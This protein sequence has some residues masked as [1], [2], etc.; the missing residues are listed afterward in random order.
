M[1]IIGPR[2]TD[3]VAEASVALRLECTGEELVADDSRAPDVRRGGGRGGPRAARRSDSHLRDSMPTNVLMPQM[4]ESIAEGTIVRWVKKVG[5]H[6]DR[7]EPLFEISTD[8]VDAEIPSPAAGVLT[9]IRAKEGETVAGQPRRRRSSTPAPGAAVAAG[10]ARGAAAGAAAAAAPPARRRRQ[11]R[12]PAPAPAPARRGRRRH[13]RGSAPPE[14]VARRPEDRRR[15]RR[16]HLA[17]RRVRHRRPR[18]QAGH[19]RASSRG[20]TAP[21]PAAA[22]RRRAGDAGRAGRRARPATRSCR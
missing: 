11:R 18:D 6:V 9:E 10:R 8:K 7:D 14:V 22:R 5:D 21:A 20:R 19:P 12:P 4:G 1:H 3:L 16:R 13:G 17:D 15:A 2:A